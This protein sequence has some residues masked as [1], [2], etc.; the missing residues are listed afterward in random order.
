MY[1]VKEDVEWRT[2][3][4]KI[5][6]AVIYR[7]RARVMYRNSKKEKME[8]QGASELYWMNFSKHTNLKFLE[9]S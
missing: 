9:N 1:S 6:L 4:N 3:T 8:L 2:T 7:L 5:T